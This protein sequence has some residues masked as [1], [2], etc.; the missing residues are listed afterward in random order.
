M[1]FSLIDWKVM[2]HQSTEGK[3]PLNNHLTKIS[4]SSN[5]NK[6]YLEEKK[7][8]TNHI[9]ANETYV[10]ILISWYNNCAFEYL[11]LLNVN[12]GKYNSIF[13]IVIIFLI[14]DDNHSLL[15]YWLDSKF[16]ITFG[17]KAFLLKHV[18]SSQKFIYGLVW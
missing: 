2:A 14:D 7:C 16:H 13:L 18:E 11:I 15:Y 10:L 3:Y 1:T 9:Q 4:N 8:M 6:L 12:V 5:L 17:K